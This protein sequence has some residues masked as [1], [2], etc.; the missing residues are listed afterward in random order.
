MSI[1]GF[2]V[3]NCFKK[4]D[5]YGCVLYNSVIFINL[6]S[7][8]FNILGARM[9]PACEVMVLEILPGIRAMVARKLVEDHGFSQKIAAERLGTTQPAI[10]QYKREIRGHRVKMFKNN[11]KLLGMIGS[12]VK[13]TA[14]GEL[15]Q[16]QIILEFCEMCKFIRSSGIACEAHKR[17]YPSLEKCRICLD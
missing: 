7:N 14:S 3:L 17:I 9:K 8:S 16:E 1:S 12:L 2:S 10:S 4:W 11:P 6:Y 13:R 15:S 5:F